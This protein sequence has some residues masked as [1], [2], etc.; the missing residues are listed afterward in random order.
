MTP[1]ESTEESLIVS[2]MVLSETFCSTTDLT[3][4]QDGFERDGGKH[5]KYGSAAYT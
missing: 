5:G 2:E 3:V 1:N 4:P